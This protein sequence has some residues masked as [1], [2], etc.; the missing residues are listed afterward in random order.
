MGD[1]PLEPTA[2]GGAILTV[3]PESGDP[4]ATAGEAQPTEEELIASAREILEQRGLRVVDPSQAAPPPT[5]VSQAPAPAAAAEPVIPDGVDM[6]G[7][8]PYDADYQEQLAKR[9][10]DFTDR[11]IAAVVQAQ[12]PAPNPTMDGVARRE[13]VSRMV[14][15]EP[16][17]KGLEQQLE[18]L[19]EI[20][21]LD[22]NAC[23]TLMTD[24]GNLRSAIQFAYGAVSLSAPA[25]MPAPV[26]S[27]AAPAG[28]GRSAKTINFTP[29][30]VADLKMLNALNA[31]V[32][33]YDPK[34]TAARLARE[35][36]K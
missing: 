27:A 6:S 7:L 8:D 35:L 22:M 20:Q 24:E 13:L 16:K 1:P 4:I 17:L 32:E 19:P 28:G 12:K 14:A 33:G 3:D 5:P 2:E 9:I 31:D 18:S 11:R 29:E 23:N 36:G 15:K 21:E 34:R 10:Q 30:E 25:P 26:G